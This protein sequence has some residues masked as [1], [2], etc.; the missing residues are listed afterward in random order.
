MPSNAD[1]RSQTCV[2]QQDRKALGGEGSITSPSPAAS[3]QTKH[4]N[5]NRSTFN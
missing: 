4:T 3:I 1:R 2:I 5:E